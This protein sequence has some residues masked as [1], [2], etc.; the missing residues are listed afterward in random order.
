M[1]RRRIAAAAAA[2]ALLLSAPLTPSNADDQ[3]GWQ[4]LAT[5]AARTD[6]PLKGFMPFG[7]ELGDKADAFPHTM[8]WFYLPLDAVV[9]GEKTYDWT[10]FE[11][12]LEAIKS[13]G[14]QAVFR[15]YLDYP[16]KETGVPEHLL[17]PGGIDQ[18]R[19]Y[20]VGE[21][22]KIRSSTGNQN[23]VLNFSPDYEDPRIQT[24]ITDFVAAFGAKYDGDPRIGFITT[25]LVGFWGEQHTWPM[26]GD[27]ND[28]LNPTL[29]NWMPSRDVEL[30]F[31]KAWDQAFDKTRLLNRNPAAD[32]GQI[33]V[34]FHDD[35]FAF[36]T[37]PTID[38]HFMSRMD[39]A[40]LKELW[41]TKPI[42]GEVYP[43]IQL[44]LF[45]PA[46][47]CV[48]DAKPENFD[49]A[50]K[51]THASWLINH[52]AW[53]TGFTGEPLER[54]KAAHASLGYDFAVTEANIT[55]T[56][57]KATVSLRVTNRG[58]APFYYD[59]PVEFAVLGADGKV[60]SSTT[61][62]ANLPSLLPNEKAEWTATLPAEVGTVVVRI[63]NAMPGGAPIRFANANQDADFPGYL[64]IGT[65][66][67][68]Q[69]PSP[70]PSASASSKPAPGLPKTG[71]IAVQ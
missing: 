53:E 49:E 32:L 28:G 43:E 20:T 18:S 29:A 54:A 5:T 39:K 63:P 67:T 57:D 19:T 40:G 52:K 58:V 55:T 26:N 17:G 70:A 9:K 51:A 59:W 69:S 41:R 7:A 37:L 12:E 36:S 6:N 50:V 8:E 25:G 3:T 71:I 33:D 35:S 2:A 34:G 47:P 4:P 65:I 64:T 11:A 22:G 23:Q 27:Y 42:G 48:N 1:L 62:E 66:T 31:Y 16:T 61:V 15:F 38:W 13:R 60:L 68:K 56:G 14:H 44:C 30:S 45:D 21:D 24:L 46:Q 10:Q